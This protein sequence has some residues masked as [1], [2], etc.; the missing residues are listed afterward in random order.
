[1]DYKPPGKHEKIFKPYQVDDLFYLKS[2]PKRYHSEKGRIKQKI[3]AK[4]QMRYTGPHRVLEVKN[5]VLYVAL[6]DGRRKMV[7]ALKM[8]RD[9]STAERF[10]GFEDEMWDDNE[11]ESVIDQ[12][13][14]DDDDG[15]KH[16]RI[17]DKIVNKEDDEDQ[18]NTEHE[19]DTITTFANKMRNKQYEMKSYSDSDSNTDSD[20]ED[21]SYFAKSN[22]DQGDQFI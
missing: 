17:Q 14:I 5:P 2:I 15:I 6:V 12:E 20:E 21:T 7:H 16:E 9:A 1:V 8:K 22:K 3:T 11:Q 13:D 18:T 4:L 10:V 19:D